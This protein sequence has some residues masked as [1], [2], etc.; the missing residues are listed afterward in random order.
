MLLSFK[1]LTSQQKCLFIA[2]LRVVIAMA[3][4]AP[5]SNFG[6]KMSEIDCDKDG[7]DLDQLNFFRQQLEAHLSYSLC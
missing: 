6:V 1:H 7:V 2:W 4:A 3:R 5:I